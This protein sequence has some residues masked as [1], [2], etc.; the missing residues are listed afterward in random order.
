[1]RTAENLET[2]VKAAVKTIWKS[3][4]SEDK[5]TYIRQE[6]EFLLQVNHEN[7]IKCYD[8]FEDDH[9]VN[10]VLDLI[11]G[12]DLYD[13]IMNMPDHKIPE[14]SCAELFSQ[15]IYAIQYL[16]EEKDI[17]H[18][19]IK[20]ENFLMKQEGTSLKVIL[21][22]FG[23]ALKCP[24]GEFLKDRVGS[25]QYMAPEQLE[26]E[27]L[28]DRRADYWALGVVL[29][30][31]LTGKQPFSRKDGDEALINNIIKGKIN[32]DHAYFYYF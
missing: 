22:D 28:H 18:R 12:G 1:V 14:A 17:C 23:F 25:L 4:F 31:M 21:I 19:D 6:I 3:N 24:E 10:F 2:K 30:N 32:F 20:P 7:I 9:S 8:I 26:E 27:S 11:E 5:L 15:M 29:F 16:H 13:Y